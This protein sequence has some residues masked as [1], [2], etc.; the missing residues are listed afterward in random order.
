MW[1]PRHWSSPLVT[2]WAMWREGHRSTR[3]QNASKG[4][5]RDTFATLGDSKTATLVDTL[6]H[7]SRSAGRD[8]RGHFGLCKGRV[9]VNTLADT[10][11]HVKTDRLRDSLD[12]GRTKTR[13]VRLLGTLAEEKAETVFNTLANV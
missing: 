2:H 8:T 7:A 13:D 9:Q 12:N 6:C 3:C 4:K 5:G 11:A 1:R 10:I